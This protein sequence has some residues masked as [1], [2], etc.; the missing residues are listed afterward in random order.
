ML[1]FT[2]SHQKI[3]K[4]LSRKILNEDEVPTRLKVLSLI[5]I[6]LSAKI[7]HETK[8]QLETLFEDVED[9]LKRKI[10]SKG[11]TALEKYLLNE[12]ELPYLTFLK[13][14]NFWLMIRNS[15]LES[16]SINLGFS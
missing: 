7:N 9:R 15:S 5:N 6:I 2:S 1:K 10:N 3:V 4:A 12:F 13:K 16:D 11:L 14:L 8:L